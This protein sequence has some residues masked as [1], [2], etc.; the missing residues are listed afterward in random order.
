[1]AKKTETKTDSTKP[2]QFEFNGV[3]LDDPD[4]NMKPEEVRDFYTTHYPELASAGVK[5]PKDLKTATVWTFE[6]KTG[7]KG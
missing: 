4:P 3:K 5:G 7:T 6:V 1:M 2:R